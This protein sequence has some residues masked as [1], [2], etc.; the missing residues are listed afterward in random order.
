MTLDVFGET[1]VSMA[2]KLSGTNPAA[3]ARTIGSITSLRR[4][5]F[6]RMHCPG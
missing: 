4:W 1:L 3:G 6:L 2:V 5:G